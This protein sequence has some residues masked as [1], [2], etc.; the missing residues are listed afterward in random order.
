MCRDLFA[1]IYPFSSL[2]LVLVMMINLFHQFEQRMQGRMES[3]QSKF[4]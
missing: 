1:D 2:F 3:L 4:C